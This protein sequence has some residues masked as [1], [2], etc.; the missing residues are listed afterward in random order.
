MEHFFLVGSTE[1]A[2][3]VA[4]IEIFGPQALLRSLAVAS[5]LRTRGTGSLL[6]AHV[7][8]HARTHGVREMFLLT[9]SALTFF[10]HRGYR[11]VRRETA[12]ASIRTTREFA[13]VCP[14][15]SAFMMKLLS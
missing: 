12:P 11:A 6:V 13:E 10:T 14:A 15:S 4:G 3:G 1:A 5:T 8:Q 7:E 2:T 9:T